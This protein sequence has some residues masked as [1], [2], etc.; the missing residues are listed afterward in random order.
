VPADEKRV[1]WEVHL[2][3]ADLQQDGHYRPCHYRQLFD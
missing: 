1:L 3:V 2:E